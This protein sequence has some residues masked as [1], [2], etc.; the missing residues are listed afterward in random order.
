MICSIKAAAQGRWW[1]GTAPSRSPTWRQCSGASSGALDHHFPSRAALV[2]AVVGEFDDRQDAE[3]VFV[4]P[5]PDVDWAEREHRR[6]ELS[7]AS[8]TTADLLVP[9]I[10][11]SLAV[12]PAV[13]VIEAE[14]RERVVDEA[15]GGTR[16]GQARGDRPT[17][18]PGLAA[19]LIIG[20]MRHAMA[21]AL[22][23]R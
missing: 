1:R 12:E 10:L 14:R 17:V 21:R 18:D 8:T 13:A 4:D 15:A 22:L 6:T 9:V 11:T 23:R 3:A 19:A 16:S 20:G 5:A 2:A 7:Y